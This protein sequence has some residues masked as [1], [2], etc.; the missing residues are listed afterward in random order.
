MGLLKLIS[1]YVRYNHWANKTMTQWLK[2]LERKILYEETRSSFSSIDLTMQ[3]MIR[4]QNFWFAVMTGIDV[5]KIDET[6][7]VNSVDITMKD[8]LEGSQRVLDKVRTYRE[9]DLLKEVPSR[10]MVQRR[11]EYILQ[12]VNHNSYHRGQI[13]TL[14]RFLGVANNIPATDY[15]VFL[16]YEMQRRR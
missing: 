12:M 9:V 16:W 10:D 7:S 15:E 11:Y 2:T 8:L 3:H 14:S 1:G 4:A 5:G 13:V 6:T